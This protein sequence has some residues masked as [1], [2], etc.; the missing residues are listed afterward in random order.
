MAFA[1]WPSR[2]HVADSKSPATNYEY[3]IRTDGKRWYVQEKA[4]NWIWTDDIWGGYFD[5][6]EKAS[7]RVVER[8]EWNKKWEADRSEKQ[9]FTNVAHWP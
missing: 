5:S 6:L 3:R 8:M 9:A 4:P 7:N 1:L 2:R